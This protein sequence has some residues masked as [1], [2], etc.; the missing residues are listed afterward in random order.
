[1]L[2]YTAVIA[3]SGQGV[4]TEVV[5]SDQIPAH[6]TYVTNSVRVNGNA[7]TDAADGDNVL[8]SNNNIVVD[9]GTLGAGGTQTITFSVTIQ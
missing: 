3:N 5:F 7:R 1:V 8:V 6:T 9:L 4:A 2:T